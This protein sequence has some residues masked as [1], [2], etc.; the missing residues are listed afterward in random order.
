MGGCVDDGEE[1]DEV[2]SVAGGWR[3]ERMEGRL[4]RVLPSEFGRRAGVGQRQILRVGG[5]KIRRE[6]GEVC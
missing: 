1:P 4:G 3:H 6:R 2:G 5:L